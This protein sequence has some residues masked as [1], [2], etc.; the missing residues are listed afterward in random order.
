MT[1]YTICY[2]VYSCANTCKHLQNIFKQID[3]Y[4][5]VAGGCLAGWLRPAR[6][7]GHCQAAWHCAKV[8]QADMAPSLVCCV[9]SKWCWFSD[10][11]PRL[12]LWYTLTFTFFQINCMMISIHVISQFIYSWYW[13][14]PKFAI[15]FWC[16]ANQF[17]SRSSIFSW[18]VW[19]I[20]QSVKCLASF[21]EPNSFFV[22]QDQSS[23]QPVNSHLK[24]FRAFW[25]DVYAKT[26]WA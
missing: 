5:I 8:R 17:K 6:G 4:Q 24:P 3:I 14:M 21:L 9:F 22:L 11:Q 18:R 19:V 12:F 15:F 23:C 2:I 10:F 26:T 7:R 16:T 20:L 25:D 1:I 13:S